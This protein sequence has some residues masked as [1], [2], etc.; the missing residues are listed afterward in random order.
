L[1]CYATGGGLPQTATVPA[2]NLGETTG[3]ARLA[4]ILD[5]VPT[6][7]TPLRPAAGRGAAITILGMSDDPYRR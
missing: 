3:L 5:D 7:R 1:S 4:A 6:I 2:S